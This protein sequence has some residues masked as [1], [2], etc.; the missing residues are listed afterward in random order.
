MG[1]ELDFQESD[2]ELAWPLLVE[3]VGLLSRRGM[4]KRYAGAVAVVDA[5]LIPT[6]RGEKLAEA[7]VWERSMKYDSWGES[8]YDVNARTK[9]FMSARDRQRSRQTIRNGG[10]LQIGDFNW[11]GGVYL[12][13]FGFGFSGVEPEADELIAA[14]FMNL[15]RMMARRRV[16]AENPPECPS[17]D[18]VGG[19]PH[20]SLAPD[21]MEAFRD[22]PDA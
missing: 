6:D 16:D 5:R 7:V 14:T 10:S 22:P 4:I 19:Q 3:F 2:Y 21:W 13:G 17:E 15:V 18:F 20:K 9:A 1:R 8:R 12:N 11:A